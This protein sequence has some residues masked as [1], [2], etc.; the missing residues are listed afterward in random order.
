MKK[1]FF[2]ICTALL[3]CFTLLG[4]FPESVRAERTGQTYPWQTLT[5]LPA[6][7]QQLGLVTHN[8]FIYAT[9]GDDG[10]TNSGIGT[11]YYAPILGD[12]SIGS[13]ILDADSI[14]PACRHRHTSHVI[15]GYLYII[16]G[17]CAGSAQAS[18]YYAFVNPDGSLGPFNIATSMPGGRRR[19]T[20]WVKNDYLFVAGGSNPGYDTVFSAKIEDDGTINSWNSSPHTLPD[21]RY[22]HS[23]VLVNNY[24]YIFGGSDENAVFQNT[25]FY[26][27]I[28]NDGT[29]NAWQTSTNTLPTTLVKSG[30]F[31]A[32]GYLYVVGGDTGSGTAQSTIYMTKQQPDGSIGAWSLVSQSLPAAREYHAVTQSATNAYVVGGD[33]DATFGDSVSSVYSLSLTALAHFSDSTLPDGGVDVP[34]TKQLTIVDGQGPYIVSIAGGVLPPGLTVTENGLLTGRPTTAGEYTFTLNIRDNTDTNTQQNFSVKIFTDS[35]QDGTADNEEQ[36]SP[37]G[38]DINN[39]SVLDALQSTVVTKKNSITDNFISITTDNCSGG[40]SSFAIKSLTD[41]AINDTSYKYPFGLNTFTAQCVTPGISG[42]FTIY[43]DKVYDT[44]AWRIRKYSP[45]IGF[46]DFTNNV[47]TETVLVG[48]LPVTKLT[49][50]VEDGSIYDSDGLA[51]GVIVDPVGIALL[52]TKS[53]LADTGKSDI[54]V[55]VLVLTPLFMA[56]LVSKIREVLW[57]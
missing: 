24:A 1:R 8:G 21:Q 49:Y 20:S 22:W 48:S 9:G 13:W 42:R 16:G 46:V 37:L 10:I 47:T 56:L 30:A 41:M 44:D 55:Y 27:L 15:K 23:S 50:S 26:A 11:V 14:M 5:S 18:V 25:V 4:Y 52:D 43:L 54:L 40:F 34:Y 6:P 19:A 45:A 36:L 29:T 28:N 31:T 12:G 53:L 2:A 51:N 3:F 7:R 35:D 38:T 57:H 33:T 39:D 17:N 32:N